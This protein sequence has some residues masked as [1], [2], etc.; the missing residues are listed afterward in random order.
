MN[1]ETI[2][3]AVFV[4]NI[5]DT[6]ALKQ[7]KTWQANLDDSMSKSK[8][9]IRSLADGFDSLQGSIAQLATAGAAFVTLKSG[10]GDVVDAYNS[11][12]ASMNGVKA[13][14]SATGN[15]VAESLAAV[16]GV[17]A[18]GLISQADAAASIKN[19]QLYGYS[20]EQA[21]QLINVMT[22]AA[23][24]NRQA[25]YS[26]SEA[27]RVTTEGIRMENS[28]LSDAS[29]ITKNIAK[30]YEEY[31]AQI[32]KTSNSLTQAE[33]AQAVYNGVLAEGGVFAGNAESYTETL[34]GAQ[35][36]LST[37]TDQV[38][39]S[40]GAAF[41]Q[42]APFISGIADW[43]A[44]N[45]ELVAGI[46]MFTGIL[47]GGSGLVSGL[48]LAMGAI[49]S[50]KTALLAM[51]VAQKFAVAGFVGLAAAAA[52]VAVIAGMEKQMDNLSDSLN[53]G[54]NNARHTE[55][56]IAGLKQQ[57]EDAAEKTTNLSK[58]LRKLD[59]D[60]QSN[61]KSIVT[62][63]QN[64]LAT[65]TQQIEEA[66]V[67]YRRAID[68]RMADFNVTLAKQERSHQETVDEL[69]TQLSFLQRY[70]NNYNKEKLAQVKF[71]LAKEEQLYKNETARQQEEIDLQN[72]ADKAKLD[73]RLAS[74]QQELEEEQ[75]FL[76]KHRE[77]VRSVQNFITLDE[78]EE[79][80]RRNAE[81]RESLA[82]QVAEAQAAGEDA[83][84]A[85]QKAWDEYME[86]LKVNI[87]TNGYAEGA[88]LATDFNKGLIDK[89][90]DYISSG[91]P[92]ASIWKALLGE[93]RYN[94]W[95]SGQGAFYGGWASGGYTGRGGVNEVAGVVHR[96]EYVVP[97]EQVD[98]TTGQPKTGNTSITINLSGILATSQ[99]AKRDLAQEI[100]KA[101]AQTEQARLA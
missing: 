91:G 27:V 80:K 43:I 86:D 15:D 94:R 89:M 72:A 87:D 61:L 53:T 26:V 38:K 5:Q 33:K 29:G 9:S 101:L 3:Q 47:I 81:Q 19:L 69:M 35:Q 14:A 44:E 83:S 10:I 77:D 100:M 50:V 98:Q 25:N 65:L 60:Y 52:G 39:Q 1:N 37:A 59:Y 23:V 62:K 58:Q 79:L 96:G 6:E 56:E 75:A 74:L 30:M 64:S 7:L 4:I 49:N 21:T 18:G 8:D 51:S 66:N 32:G 24:Y 78:I 93:E 54:A 85:F 76:E 34:A 17:T 70:N 46:T 57:M 68:E 73:A 12:E 99:Q 42:F 45:K 13:V 82:K 71:A 55:A 95:T 16:K 90:G 84:I 11:F 31:A 36:K 88:K 63:H 48:K 41:A 20:I 28:V 92:A 97:A 40:I 22:D 2:G 67:D